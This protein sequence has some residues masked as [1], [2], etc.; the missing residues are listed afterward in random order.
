MGAAILAAKRSLR[1]GVGKLSILTPQS[2]VEIL[3]NSIIKVMIEFNN[4]SLYLFNY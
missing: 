3:Q 1:L 2:G 4:L